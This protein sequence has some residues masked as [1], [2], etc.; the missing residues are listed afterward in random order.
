LITRTKIR[1]EPRLSDRK[2]TT[3]AVSLR[4]NPVDNAKIVLGVN[5]A[6]IKTGNFL[7]KLVEKNKG[8]NR[9]AFSQVSV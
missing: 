5:A 9:P 8:T 4:E 7:G 6:Y 1:S 2:D 3:T